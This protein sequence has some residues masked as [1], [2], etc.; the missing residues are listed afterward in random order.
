M[1][2]PPRGKLAFPAKLDD[3]T[4][5]VFQLLEH[6]AGGRTRLDGDHVRFTVTVESK[7]VGTTNR[8]GKGHV[9]ITHGPDGPAVENRHNVART[10]T[11]TLG[12]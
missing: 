5:Q 7:D 2:M 3:L 10:N 4:K 11:G 8:V 6:L 12:R 9:E 1:T